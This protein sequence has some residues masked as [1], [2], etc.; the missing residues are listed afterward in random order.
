[1]KKRASVLVSLVLVMAMVMTGCGGDKT[2]KEYDFDLSEYVTVGEYKGLEYT[3]FD[4]EV[5][6]EEIDAEIDAVL[7]ENADQVELTEGTIEEGDY[8][9][10]S[11]DLEVNGEV[12]EGVTSE[13]YTIEVGAGHILDAIDKGVIGRDLGETFEV[14][15]TF[16]EDYEINPDFAGQ[17]AKFTITITKL[18]DVTFP[19]L[20]DAFAMK[21]L[22][23]D[24]IDEYMENLEQTMYDTKLA[25]ARYMAGEEI[26]AQILENSEVI[27]YPEEKVDETYTM[28]IDNF[29]SLV[30]QYGM[31]META[32]ESMNMT[33]EDYEAQ[34]MESAEGAV[35]EEM[36]LY[37]IAREN[38][39]ELTAEDQ[40]TYV[41]S[42]LSANEMTEEDFEKTYGMTI[43]E[44]LDES[45]I[46]ISLLYENVFYFLVDNGVAK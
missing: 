7:K 23:F 40:Q 22:G 30:Q 27:K 44:Y 5:T 26:W 6:Q 25:D 41:D 37:S 38:D 43:E 33:Q 31:D 17:P 18:Y 20:N 10:I 35:K 46:L 32:L 12:M 2:V 39:L 16:P 45:G 14:N 28:L 36:I 24:T 9:Q 3:A 19:E 11:Y 42:L 21:V 8:I 34:M 13:G 1:M 15:T 4:V 29:N